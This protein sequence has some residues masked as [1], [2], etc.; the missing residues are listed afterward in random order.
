MEIGRNQQVWLPGHFEVY[1]ILCFGTVTAVRGTPPCLL[2]LL[3]AA[4]VM[5]LIPDQ[6]Q[7]P[8]SGCVANQHSEPQSVIV[9]CAGVQEAGALEYFRSVSYEVHASSRARSRM[10]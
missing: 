4:Q 9:R 10:Q 2:A 3:T 8:L 7:Q 6:E 5:L 1:H